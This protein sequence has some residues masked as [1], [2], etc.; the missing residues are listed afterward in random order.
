MDG[1]AESPRHFT[2]PEGRH[3]GIEQLR[4]L[5][6]RLQADATQVTNQELVD[7]KAFIREQR[8]HLANQDVSDEVIAALEELR[9]SFSA[10]KTVQDERATAAAELD[11]KRRGL[12]SE[13]E[14]TE[15]AEDTTTES[16]PGEGDGGE[17]TEG[18]PATEPT[19]TEQPTGEPAAAEPTETAPESQPLAASA[20]P[21]ARRAPIGAFRTPAT[22]RPPQDERL[23]A[24]TVVTAAGGSPG[25]VQGQPINSTAELAKAFADQIR[26][27]TTGKSGGG[28]KV[29]VANATTTYPEERTLRQADWVGNFTKIERATEPSVLTAAGGIC[30]PLQPLYDVLVIGSAA[31]PVRDALARFGVDRGGIQFRPSTSAATV[32]ADA[33]GTWTSEQDADDSGDTKSCYPVVCPPVDEAMVYAVYLCLEFSNI[34]ARFDPESTA[35]NVRQG[36]ITHARRAENELLRLIQAECKVLSAPKVIGATRDILANLDKVSAYYRNRHR[37]DTE[38]SLTCILPAWVRFLMRTDIAR[39]MAA[40]DWMQA[41]G[42][43][44]TLIEQWFRNRYVTPAWHLDGGIG[45]SNEVQT[46]TVTGAPTGGTYTLTFDGET[47]AA[48][49]YNATAADVKDALDDLPGVNYSDVTTAGGPHPGT[50]IT[51]A[52]GGQYEMVNVPQMTAS[53]AGLTGGSSPTVTPTTTTAAGTTSTVNGVSIA[54]QVYGNAAAGA[55]IPGYPDQVDA[56]LFPTG[57]ILFLDGG[58]LDLGLVRDSTLNSR[59]RYR[60]FSETFE[61]IANRAVEPLRL[62]MTVQPTGETAGTANTSGITD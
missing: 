5:L 57:S 15:P 24:R 21:P 29:Y 18:E 2:D 8:G 40:G 26:A 16:S 12:L 38:I 17:P 41:L 31:R 62:A 44:D 49:P 22:T 9:D 14:D 43:A 52:F 35:A 19:A 4:E 7:A 23:V 47:T 28:G 59:N 34:S 51:V 50:A 32:L 39:Q 56:L 10:I 53:S 25:F 20:K 48:I 30:A 1:L 27:M 61:G 42:V 13:I 3:M 54:S 45:G 46:L 60:Q 6:E 11:E 33:V 58:T 37:I 55:A 36:L